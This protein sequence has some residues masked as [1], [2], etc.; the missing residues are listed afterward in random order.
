[1]W[2]IGEFFASDVQQKK[3]NDYHAY[4][5]TEVS[6]NPIGMVKPKS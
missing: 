4:Q 1:M 3:L 6:G 2:K 5:Q